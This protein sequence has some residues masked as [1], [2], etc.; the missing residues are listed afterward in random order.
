MLL[1]FIG[2]L[3]FFLFGIRLM[4]NGL[5]DVAGQ[6]LR[7]FLRGATKRPVIGLAVG[8]VVT[9]LIQSSSATTTM[10]VGLANA[11]LLSL[12]QAIS[13]VLGANIGTTITAWMVAL[14]GVN[15]DVMKFALPAVG[16]GFFFYWFSKRRR[17]KLW[18][19]VLLG[20]G[21]R[22]ACRRKPR[23]MPLSSKKRE[24]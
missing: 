16:A 2:G 4:S 15:I 14:V 11:G 8:T 17:N 10:V 12:R 24:R 7:G 9:A 21:V 6:R 13:L 1:T 19:Q 3:G 23:L 20:L 18:G 5:R 22:S